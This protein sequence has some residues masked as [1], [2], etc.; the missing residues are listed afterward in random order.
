MGSR[1]RVKT[2]G[3]VAGTNYHRFRPSQSAAE[4]AQALL[5]AHSSGGPSST[6]SADSSGS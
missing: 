6:R 1:G 2:V 3:Q 5:A 4:I